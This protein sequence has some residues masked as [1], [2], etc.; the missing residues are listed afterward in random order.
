M[1]AEQPLSSPQSQP[2]TLEEARAH[3]GNLTWDIAKLYPVQGAWSEWEYMELRP[4]RVVEY[5]H[6]F[7]EIHDGPSQSHQLI[8]A[9]LY[10]ALL[11][12]VTTHN[13]GTVLFA[14]LRVKLWL[15]K[16]REPDIVF[17]FAQNAARRGEDFWIGTDLAIEIVSEGERNRTRDLEEKRADYAKGGVPEYWIVDP[18]E[19]KITVLKLD[20]ETY[21]VHGEFAP[22]A[23]A[24]S[25]LLDG[26]TVDVT[27]VFAAAKQ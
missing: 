19:Q 4:S 21:T 10:Q 16:Y 3:Y 13:L 26:F 20:G 8:L 2:H 5:D 15:E 6:G 22:G 11:A 24:T 1:S 23:T 7:V 25:A 9:F 27:A 17:M 18:Q 12:F 14:P